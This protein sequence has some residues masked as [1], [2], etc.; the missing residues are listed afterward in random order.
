MV[1]SAD[2]SARAFDALGNV[3]LVQS[4]VRIDAE[5]AGCVLL[6]TSWRDGGRCRTGRWWALVVI[7]RST[8]IIDRK[9]A[10]FTI[11]GRGVANRD[12]PAPAGNRDVWQLRRCSLILKLEQVV[13]LHQQRVHGARR[14]RRNSSTCWTPYSRIRRNLADRDRPR[15]ALRPLSNL[16]RCVVFLWIGKRTAVEDLLA[17]AARPDRSRWSARPAP[18]NR[19]RSPCCTAHSIRSRVSSGSTAWTSAA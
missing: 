11:R 1:T 16:G 9:L 5:C 19:R 7:T 8:P 6:P 10:I 18:A 13:V 14:C 15:T 2:L 3:A 4:F 12:S 17:G